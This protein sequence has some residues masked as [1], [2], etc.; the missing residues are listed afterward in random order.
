MFYLSFLRKNKKWFKK[1]WVLTCMF[2]HDTTKDFLL[3]PKSFAFVNSKILFL[4]F[5]CCVDIIIFI[6]PYFIQRNMTKDLQDLNKV[7]QFSIDAGISAD[8]LVRKMG[9]SGVM[10]AGRI[11]TATDIITTMFKDKIALFFWALLGLLC[12]EA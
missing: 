12:L 11:S 4:N 7:E 8:E 3:C 9:K 1:F 10:G 6:N 5:C 2:F